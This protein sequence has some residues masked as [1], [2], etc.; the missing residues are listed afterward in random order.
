MKKAVMIFALCTLLC[1]TA[2]AERST[3]VGTIDLIEKDYISVGG[4]QYKLLNEFSEQMTK[5]KYGF[6]TEYWVFIFND[7]GI[8]IRSYQVTF[9]TLA[10]VGYVDKAKVIFRNGMVSKIEVIDLQQ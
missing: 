4:K 1:G 3:I 9:N 6:E 2:A 5:I 8:P 10:G 7:N